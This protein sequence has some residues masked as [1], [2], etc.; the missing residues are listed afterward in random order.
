M[1]YNQYSV[2][3]QF[4]LNRLL[5]QYIINRLELDQYNLIEQKNI[6]E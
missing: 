4:K 1:E 5:E 2:K 3:N 6:K